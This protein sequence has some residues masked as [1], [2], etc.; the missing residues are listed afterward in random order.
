M[1]LGATISPMRGGLLPVRRTPSLCEG[2][3]A[4]RL[5]VARSGYSDDALFGQGGNL[6]VISLLIRS[7]KKIPVLLVL[8]VSITFLTAGAATPL[9]LAPACCCGMTCCPVNP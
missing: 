1:S 6:G 5:C 9:L 2:V 4:S 8:L 3:G 7:I